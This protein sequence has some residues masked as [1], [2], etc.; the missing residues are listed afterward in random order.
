MATKNYL[1]YEG[2]GKY[3]AKVQEEIDA[4]VDAVPG[5]QLS[6]NDFTAQDKSKLDGLQ[7]YTL[8][9]SDTDTLGGVMIETASGA[10]VPSKTAL[11]TDASGKAYVDWTEAPKASVTEAGLIKLG[12]TFKVG[13]DGTVDVD[14]DKVGSHE[15]AWSD[16]TGKPQLAEKSDLV[17]VYRY[18]GSVEAYDN[19]PTQD[20]EVGD[21][22]DVKSTGM[23][24]AWTGTEWDA[25][26]QSF[27]IT[28]I[29]DDQINQL[30]AKE[31]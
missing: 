16:I 12:G 23:N 28:S 6:T 30:F 15:V 10:P 26:G 14:K 31:D 9:V 13:E 8:P 25:L 24:Y 21:V 5:K 19:L 20:R 2:L 1:D 18:K 11:K 27:E 22:Y 7:N 17:S 4:K 29:T 3:H